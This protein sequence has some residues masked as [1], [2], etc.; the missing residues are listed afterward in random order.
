MAL[1]RILWTGRARKGDSPHEV[2]RGTT[3]T[4]PTDETIVNEVRTGLANGW[5]VEVYRTEEL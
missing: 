2:Q 3:F 5:R 4:D 1:V